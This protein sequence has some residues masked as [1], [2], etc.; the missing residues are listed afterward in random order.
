MSILSSRKTSGMFFIYVEEHH[1]VGGHEHF[2]RKAVSGD[3][4]Q[5]KLFCKKRGFEYFSYNNFF[6]K[7]QYFL[8]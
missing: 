5:Y 4:N 7:K 3:K 1:F 2:E 8:K 6:K